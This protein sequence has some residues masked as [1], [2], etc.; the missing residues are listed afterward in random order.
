MSDISYG[1]IVDAVDPAPGARGGVASSLRLFRASKSADAIFTNEGKC[2]RPGLIVLALLLWVSRRRKLVLSE[3][4]PG[5]LTGLNGRVVTAAYRLLLPRVLLAAQVMTQWERDD[6]AVRYGIPLERLKLIPFYSYDDRVEPEP[7]AW[8]AKERHG[9][10]STG[11][12]SCDWETLIA[13]AQDEDWPLTIVCRGSER[14]KYE[15]DAAAAGV[16]IRSDIPRAEHDELLASSALLIMALKDRAVSAGHVRL[17]TAATHGVPVIASEIRGIAGYEELA[18]AIVPQ[19]DP[20]AL[21]ASVDDL[22]GNPDHLVREMERVREYARRRPYSVYE[23]EIAA[24]VGD[25]VRQRA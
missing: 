11:K 6:Y 15:D 5:H 19:R 1:K 2:T 25:A 12:N 3:F 23:A 9:Y 20:E 22:M 24:L 7:L 18:V 16:T 21:R 13:A 17:M 4:L 14:K 10:L 8:D